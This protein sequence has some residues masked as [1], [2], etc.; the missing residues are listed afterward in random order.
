VFLV[1]LAIA[2][3]IKFED[4][5]SPQLGGRLVH[6]PAS[7]RCSPTGG[8]DLAGAAWA[9]GGRLVPPRHHRR[10]GREGEALVRALAHEADTDLRICGVFDDRVGDRSLAGGGR[11]P[12]SA[13]STTWSSSTRRTRVD[14]I[15]V[16]LPLTARSASCTWC[17]KLWVL[18][19][20]VRLA[21][22]T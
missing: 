13:R 5:I 7:W 10:R 3:F 17:A 2:F 1:A 14:L 12:S 22:P 18:P 6:S 11:H 15:L 21:G 8:A 16:S 9:R 4:T 19:V 20:D